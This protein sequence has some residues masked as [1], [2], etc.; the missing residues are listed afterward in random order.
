MGNKQ[1]RPQIVVVTGASAGIGRATAHAFAARGAA[2]ALLARGARGLEA[3]AEEVRTAGG[4]PLPIGVD[5][6]DPEAV[7]AAATRVERELGPIDIWVNAAFSTVFAPVQEVGAEELERVMRVTYL[8]FVH[9]TQAALRRM[10]PRDHGTI[11]QVGSALAHRGVPLQSAYCAAKHAIQGF[12]ESLRCEL[13]HDRSRVRVTMVHLPGVNTPQFSWVLSR[14]PRHPQ[15]MP[16]IY[17]PEVAARGIVYAADHPRRRQYWVGGS[18]AATLIGHTF[19][20]GLLDRYL[21]RTGYS[22]Q[23]MSQPRGPHQPT[24]L[25]DPADDIDGRDYG[26]HGVFDD[27]ATNRSAQ[28][29][30][31]QH[32]GLLTAAGAAAGALVCALVLRSNR[33]ASPPAHGAARTV[34]RTTG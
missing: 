17:Q 30:A 7:E 2:V 26:T 24:N 12:H 34:R 20:P 5:V 10:A 4:H 16:P 3:A 25:W 13:L 21:A 11:V 29:W 33:H 23:Q 22:S 1:H 14:L 18:T 8:G 27:Q 6:S 32:H 28:L 9:G 31:S 15:P 19:A